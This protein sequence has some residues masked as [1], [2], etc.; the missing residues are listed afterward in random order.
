M[1]TASTDKIVIT[2][3]ELRSRP[4]ETKLRQQEAMQ[5]NRDYAQVTDVPE[6]PQAKPRWGFLYNT[7]VYMTFFGL[8]GG[9]LAWTSG[10][11]LHFKPS[12]RVEAAELM[13][14]V[15]EINRA[16]ARDKCRGGESN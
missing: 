9:L 2:W 15:Q 13:R 5:R 7:I 8:L 16:A 12:S 4:V 3:D 6:L 1:S 10:E 11:L 14:T